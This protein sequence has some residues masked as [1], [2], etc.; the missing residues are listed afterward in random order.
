VEAEQS[1]RKDGSRPDG[2][3]CGLA[4]LASALRIGEI[5]FFIRTLIIKHKHNNFRPEL[6]RPVPKVAP[7]SDSRPSPYWTL[8]VGDVC[9]DSLGIRRAK[10]YFSICVLFS[11]YGFMSFSLG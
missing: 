11:R 9:V 7:S 10:S 3:V 1:A 4:P 6:G 2:R 5:E 8:P